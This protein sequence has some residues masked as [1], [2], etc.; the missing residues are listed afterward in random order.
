MSII[1]SVTYCY[2]YNN[3]VTDES[4]KSSNPST[5]VNGEFYPEDTDHDAQ[6]ISCVLYCG[7]IGNIWN[8]RYL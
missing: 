3:S 6:V 1:I 8:I 5:D 4:K 2:Y 7:N